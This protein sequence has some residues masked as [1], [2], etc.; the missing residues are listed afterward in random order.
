[1]Y[2]MTKYSSKFSNIHNQTSWVSY[3][4]CNIFFLIMDFLGLT[5]VI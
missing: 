1:M 2:T 4:L 5:E 3:D